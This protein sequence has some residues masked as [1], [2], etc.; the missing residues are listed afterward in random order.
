M[1]EIVIKILMSKHANE[2]RNKYCEEPTYLSYFES[3]AKSISRFQ[4]QTFTIT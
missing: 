2:K 3:A 1:S 4:D